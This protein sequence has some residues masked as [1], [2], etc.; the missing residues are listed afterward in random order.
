MLE[1]SQVTVQDKSKKM[2]KADEYTV[3]T[4]NILFILSGA[5]GGIEKIV[6]SRLTTSS[7]GFEAKK[8]D[9]PLQILKKDSKEYFNYVTSQLESTDLISY[10]LIPEFVGRIPIHA[11]LN[12][13]DENMLIDALTKPKHSIVNQYTALFKLYNVSLVFTP[14]ALLEIAR[15]AI[16]KRVGARGLRTIV[17]RVLQPAMYDAP[18]SDIQVVTVEAD[19][20]K[21]SKKPVYTR[22][23]KEEDS[24]D[25][26]ERKTSKEEPK[27]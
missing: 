7:I 15:M 27:F 10:G 17:E 6:A 12:Q 4:N 14:E 23:S 16:Q 1:G 9:N 19:T 13:L 21:F 25:D 24:Q 22:T 3:D 5:F 2:G 20:V 26:V 18:H 8:S 11:V